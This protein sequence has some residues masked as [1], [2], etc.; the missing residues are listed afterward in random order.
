LVVCEGQTSS[1]GGAREETRHG[2]SKDTY[3]SFL[4]DIISV[5]RASPG[6]GYLL[7]GY[8]IDDRGPDLRRV[9]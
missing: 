8:E 2:T 6:S 9:V 5:Q 7:L 1:A 4:Q 3:G